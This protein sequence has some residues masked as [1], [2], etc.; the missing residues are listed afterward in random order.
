MISKQIPFDHLMEFIFCFIT[1]IKSLGAKAG[2]VLNPA[3]PLTAI[4]YVLDGNSPSPPP[5]LGLCIREFKDPGSSNVKHEHAD[6]D[7][8]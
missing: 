2:V 1:Q 7:L 6:F 5:P 4:E 8:Y 3:T